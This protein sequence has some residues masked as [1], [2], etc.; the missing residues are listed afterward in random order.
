MYRPRSLRLAP[1][2]VVLAILTV[3]SAAAHAEPSDPV[4]D[5]VR[6]K[7]EAAGATGAKLDFMT[8]TDGFAWRL[9]GGEQTRDAAK[10]AAAPVLY[11]WLVT[12]DPAD[13]AFELHTIRAYH[14]RGGRLRVSDR[15]L[16]VRAGEDPGDVFR[17]R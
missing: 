5:P 8:R 3:A 15:T 1:R 14:F 2:L 11:Q 7:W 17:S 13:P 12:Q 10:I 6:A 4:R 16:R 9:P